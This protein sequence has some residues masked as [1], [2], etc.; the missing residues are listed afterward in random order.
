MEIQAQAGCGDEKL[1]C[2][3]GSGI[4][5]FTRQVHTAENMSNR[6]YSEYSSISI[7]RNHK[8][9]MFKQFCGISNLPLHFMNDC[10]VVICRTIFIYCEA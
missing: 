2:K 7:R 5:K 1:V 8:M 4:V 3:N 6:Y 10:T 9:K